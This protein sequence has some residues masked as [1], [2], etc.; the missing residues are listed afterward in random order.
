MIPAGKLGIS[1]TATAPTYQSYAENQ[2]QGA[3][4][5]EEE[6]VMLL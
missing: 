3:N 1:A 2:L 5:D 4:G 6:T